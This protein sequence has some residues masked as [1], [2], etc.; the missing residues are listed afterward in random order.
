MKKWVGKIVVIGIFAVFL[1]CYLLIPSVK[2]GL[3]EIV[4]MFASGDFEVV[5]DFVKSYGVYAAAVSF[6]LMLF[7]SVAAPLPAF[8]ITFANANLF[9]WWQ[10]AILS[11]TSAMAG[12]ALCFY[13]ARVLGRDV[14]VK[15]TS[16]AGL[17]SI[18][19][20]FDKHGRQ[21]ILI[22]RLLPFMSFDI[23]SYAAGLTSMSFGSFFIA[24]GIGQLPA[25]IVYSYVGGM[26]TGGA[27]LLVTGLLILFALSVLVVLLR[28]IYL[29]RQKKKLGDV[30]Q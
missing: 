1:L 29:E 19:K 25:T 4:A 2:S 9:G 6:L 27:R 7:Q 3:N 22:A 20:F 24:T 8:L 11:W 18:D 14:V 28:Q 17:E 5:G 16:K 10:G 12:A 30:N 15:L 23:V 21:S 26:L 13:I